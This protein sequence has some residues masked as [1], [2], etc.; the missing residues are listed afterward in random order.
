M[1][2]LAPSLPKTV[3]T[4]S[5]NNE[6][7]ASVA[8]VNLNVQEEASTR[9]RTRF[10]KIKTH[11][12]TPSRNNGEI[13]STVA[14]ANEPTSTFLRPS[15]S[16]SINNED[17]RIHPPHN[18]QT[19]TLRTMRPDR[20]KSPSSVQAIRWGQISAGCRRLRPLCSFVS[21]FTHKYRQ[22]LTRYR[23]CEQV[24]PTI[25]TRQ[26]VKILKKRDPPCSELFSHTHR[27]TSAVGATTSSGALLE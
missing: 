11:C 20:M 4:S 21:S 3:P 15:A 24:Q 26:R 16:R 14:D 27:E 8:D 25:L 2:P 22:S 9:R 19:H 18:T 1:N 7:T 6:E 13:A 10:T 12:I 23:Q 5:M 17:R